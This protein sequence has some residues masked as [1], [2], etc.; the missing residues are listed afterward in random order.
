MG[1]AVLGDRWRDEGLQ[2]RGWGW[3]TELNCNHRK[4][5][6]GSNGEKWLIFCSA[7]GVSYF[8]KSR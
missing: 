3:S 8:K 6:G 2:I 4:A 5:K 1:E 7:Q